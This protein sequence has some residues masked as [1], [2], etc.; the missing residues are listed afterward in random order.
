MP[1]EKIDQNNDILYDFVVVYMNQLQKS[2]L[3]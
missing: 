2:N 3:C 1:L